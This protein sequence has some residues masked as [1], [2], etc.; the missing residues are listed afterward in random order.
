MCRIYFFIF[1][2]CEPLRGNFTRNQN[3]LV[4]RSISKLSTPFFFFFNDICRE[5]CLKMYTLFCKK[6]VDNFKIERKA[7]F[8]LW[9]GVQF[10]F[11]NSKHMLIIPNQ[12]HGEIGNIHQGMLCS[13]KLCVL[14]AFWHA[15]ITQSGLRLGRVEFPKTDNTLA[16]AVTSD[17]ITRADFSCQAKVQR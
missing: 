8:F 7:C 11:K 14:K 17:S 12:I 1:G 3:Y 2:S 15:P 4:L 10:P 13:N 6:S 5:N 9:L 16:L